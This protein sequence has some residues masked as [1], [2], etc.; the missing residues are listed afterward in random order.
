M[1]RDLIQWIIVGLIVGGIAGYVRNAGNAM[2]K[3]ATQ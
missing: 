3:G 2:P 1:S